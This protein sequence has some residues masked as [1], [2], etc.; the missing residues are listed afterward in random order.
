MATAAQRKAV[1][2]HRERS[3]AKGLAR[4]EVTAPEA[5]KQL[6]RLIAKRLTQ[7]DAEE[8]RASIGKALADRREGSVGG[9][10]RALLAS[11]LAGAN[12]TIRRDKI[13]NRKVEF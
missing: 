13:Y 1:K 4:F 10:L 8:V 9:V 12:L 5:D 3:R 6:I 11:P 2:T 7:S